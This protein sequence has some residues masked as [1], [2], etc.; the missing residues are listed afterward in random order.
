MHLQNLFVFDMSLFVLM[1]AAL[2]LVCVWRWLTNVIAKARNFNWICYF[3]PKWF[4]FDCA[5]L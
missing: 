5:M 1:I 3:S 2:E 4:L